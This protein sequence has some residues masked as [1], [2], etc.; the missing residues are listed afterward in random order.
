VSCSSSLLN[1]YKSGFDD[2]KEGKG[3][4]GLG[5]VSEA[6]IRVPVVVVKE[7]VVLLMF[8]VGVARGE[9][10]ETICIE[11]GDDTGGALLVV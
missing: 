5:V 4:A 10:G 9:A 8:V 2:L 11:G 1:S 7:A 6:V 3:I